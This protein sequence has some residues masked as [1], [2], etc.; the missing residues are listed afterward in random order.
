MPETTTPPPPQQ[1]TL[2]LSLNFNLSPT[3]ERLLEVHRLDLTDQDCGHE[4]V[5]VALRTLKPTEWFTLLFMDLRF[6]LG[7]VWPKLLGQESIFT[8]L[9][10]WVA[11][12]GTAGVIDGKDVQMISSRTPKTLAKALEIQHPKMPWRAGKLT[13]TEFR[14]VHR[15]GSVSYQWRPEHDKE[16]E[17]IEW[18]RG[19]T[20]TGVP[21]ICTASMVCD[22]R[23][24]RDVLVMCRVPHPDRKNF[25]PASPGSWRGGTSVQHFFMWGRCPFDA[26]PITAPATQ[27]ELP[28]GSQFSII[29]WCGYGFNSR[30]FYK[31]LATGQ[32]KAEAAI[33]MLD[34]LDLSP[35]KLPPG[36]KP[37][38]RRSN[39]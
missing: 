22:P 37:K 28:G 23:N 8:A 2:N 29:K 18:V 14:S 20:E 39:R 16:N 36:S 35:P 7:F 17:G 24:P 34:Q 10:G 3:L 21:F 1:P 26:P 38:S 9:T 32:S 30:K 25:L 19:Q 11:G 13:E 5:R 27:A 15:E 4:I 33:K 12:D 6:D 31:G